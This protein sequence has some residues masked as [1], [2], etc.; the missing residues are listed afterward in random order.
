MLACST[1][2]NDLMDVNM[3]TKL[4]DCLNSGKCEIFSNLLTGKGSLLQFLEAN[5]VF[6]HSNAKH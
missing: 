5:N 6:V 3:C 1:H 4:F 2:W